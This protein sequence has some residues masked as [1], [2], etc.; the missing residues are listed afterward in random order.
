MYEILLERRAEK[1][2]KNLP[3]VLF[4]LI[5]KK[6]NRWQK[7]QNLWVLAKSPDQKT[8]GEFASEIIAQSMKLMKKRNV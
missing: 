5:I 2:L 6:Y 1:D 4:Q 3:S 8:I 7:I